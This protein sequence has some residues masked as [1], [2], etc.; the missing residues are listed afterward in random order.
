[1]DGFNAI[2]E[3]YHLIFCVFVHILN[4]Y[5]LFTFFLLTIK[6]T[7]LFLA[8]SLFPDAKL[9]FQRPHTFKEIF[10]SSFTPVLWMLTYFI[11]CKL[12]E[13]LSIVI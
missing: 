3:S 8:M 1:M 7:L 9:V 13:Q 12:A 10:L 11:P 2:V 6:S 5:S 4:F